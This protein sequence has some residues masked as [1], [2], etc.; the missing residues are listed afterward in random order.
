MGQL[1]FAFDDSKLVGFTILEKLGERLP[2]L[3]H[4]IGFTADLQEIKRTIETMSDESILNMKETNRKKLD[5]LLMNLYHDLA[6]LF[7][8]VDSKRIPDTALRMLQITLSNGLCLMSPTAFALFA[9]CL[10]TAKDYTLGYRLGTIA[11]RLLVK[12]GAQ[13]CTSAVIAIVGHF[14]QWVA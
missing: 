13:R 10:V 11:L 5:L 1:R 6:Y 4:D 8:V 14:I 7:N 9:G 12:T 2:R 3:L